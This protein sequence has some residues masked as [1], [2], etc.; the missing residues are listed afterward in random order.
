MKRIYKKILLFLLPLI[1]AYSAF[2]QEKAAAPPKEAEGKE[3][4][5]AK[6]EEKKSEKAENKSPAE[7]EKSAEKDTPKEVSAE[8]PIIAKNVKT[9]LLFFDN[10]VR[11]VFSGIEYGQ[12]NP[13]LEGDNV[14]I[15]FSKPA[16]VAIQGYGSDNPFIKAYGFA[17]DNKSV[18]FR[19]RGDAAKM[20]KF[21]TDNGVGFDV[22]VTSNEE[23][24]E[25]DEKQE[26]SI[27]LM[28]ALPGEDEEFEE[29]I[30]E[31]VAEEI[32]TSLAPLIVTYPLEF[33]GPPSKD[34]K[35]NIGDD[36]VGPLASDFGNYQLYEVAK[37]F[38]DKTIAPTYEYSK[39]MFLSS[40]R[41]QAIDLVGT[42][43]FRNGNAAYLVFNHNK[44]VFLTDVPKNPIVKN[45][46]QIKNDKFTILKF[47][48]KG[49][50]SAISDYKLLAYKNKTS[51][52]IEIHNKNSKNNDGF[53][54]QLKFRAENYFG[55]NRLLFTLK[56]IS[57]QLQIE[58][59]NTGESL[60]I[61]TTSEN[62]VGNVDR[63]SFVDVVVEASA[64]GL[65]VREK[66]DY[67][68]FEK[69]QDKGDTLL[70]TKLP[71][72][73]LSE[74]V[75]AVG[76]SLTSDQAQLSK[77][78]FGI[79]SDQSIFPFELA[80]KAIKE[81]AEKEAKKKAKSKKSDEAQADN[82]QEKAGDKKSEVNLNPDMLDMAF[83]DFVVK[84]IND[85]V[86]A[87]DNEKSAFKKKLA[88]YYFRKG[89]YTESMGYLKDITTTDP[90]FQDIFNSRAMLAATKYLTEKY[91]E[92][93]EE[94]NTLV[95]ES[96]NSTSVNELKLW[97]WM[98]VFKD[99]KDRRINEKIEE[100]DF[101]AG[102][103][104]FMQQYPKTLRFAM[105]LNYIE[106]LLDHEKTD[107]AK[108]ILEIISYN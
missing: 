9:E 19:M 45:V 23:P 4:S 30:V 51:W 1:L 99:N 17:N 72:L 86:S 10:F 20:R 88:D 14:I 36:F 91:D 3:E 40:M 68:T 53:V 12:L 15:D 37:A 74:E 18:L 90:S 52:N 46:K 105:G 29:E 54:N 101:V 80:L 83:S 5:Q 67:V 106:Y 79:F 56:D 87:P 108:N 95:E 33:V 65:V 57:E 64:Q 94:F 42:A 96:A 39:G 2:A 48:L 60:R 35:Y 27:V 100:I 81:K 85:I 44:P 21:I 92:A 34:Q 7:E 8:K 98:S 103:D 78:G 76:D 75:L 97:G 47:N 77:R 59:K 22:F 32:A 107:D 16:D 26:P 73:F 55:E 63:K 41:F 38:D 84:S 43:F 31:D 89:L 49:N 25:S 62:G 93:R 24:K 71:D 102:H 61:F 13:L 104:K 66:S 50:I 82:L 58:D 70:V 6:T 28:S 11:M 69:E